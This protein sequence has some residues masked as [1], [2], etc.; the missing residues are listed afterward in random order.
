MSTDAVI[1]SAD[2][3]H[4]LLREVF[5]AV[6][7]SPEH[8]DVEADV[9]TFANL[10]GVDSHGIFRVPRYIGAIRSGEINAKPQL[11]VAKRLGAALIVE[12]DRA[13]GPV[14]MAWGMARAIEVAREA[15]LG[16][17]IVRNTTHTGPVGYYA[18]MACAEGMLG[19]ASSASR[20]IMAYH[21]TATPA[22]STNP[23]AI[24]APRE[25][26]EPIVLDMATAAI[27]WGKLSKA[28]QSGTP[29]P[30][31]VALDDAGHMT[32]DPARARI[33]L[34]L[35]GAKGA[36]L[37]V[38]IECLVSLL[39][40]QPLIAPALGHGRPPS[41]A[42]QHGLAIAIDIAALTDLTDFTLDAA[43]LAEAIKA[44]PRAEGVDD[45][46]MPGERGDREMERRREHGIPLDPGEWNKLADIAQSLGIDAKP[47]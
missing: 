42:W 35:A 2:R 14:A 17:A 37:S 22:A 7:F 36:G 16:F 43:S 46:L 23:L 19:I 41:G 31:N 47:G 24:A 10:R 45:I 4:A 1:V 44:Q 12:A 13:A 18:R 3:L 11:A 30:D 21:G 34:P 6:G 38:M 28:V 26:G 20:P 8:A 32:T 15:A 29:L 25:A 5:E 39:A 27:A 33:P 40:G 9:L